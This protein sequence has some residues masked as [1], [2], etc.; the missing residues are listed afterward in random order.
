[1]S[2]K[3][4]TELCVENIDDAVG[5]MLPRFARD[6]VVGA[7]GGPPPVRPDVAGGEHLAATFVTIR[8]R[9]SLDPRTLQGCIG[10][11]EPRRGLLDDVAHNALGA[12]FADPRATSLT[13]AEAL[14]PETGLAFEVTLLG[15]LEPITFSDEASARAALRPGIDGVVLRALGRRG[16]FLPQVWDS[17]PEPREFLDNLKLKAGLPESF[18]SPEVELL[19]YA[20]KKWTCAAP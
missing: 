10:T 17:L 9:T 18:W 2:M 8:R 11:L 20:T 15:A 14:S 4:N 3:P 5:M 12:A 19:R 6:V 13:L 1:M 7:L 16:T